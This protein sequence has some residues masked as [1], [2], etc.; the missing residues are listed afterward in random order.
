VSQI[1]RRRNLKVF[2]RLAIA[3]ATVAR[4]F[5]RKKTIMASILSMD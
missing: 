5:R 1:A 4:E 3:V 2:I